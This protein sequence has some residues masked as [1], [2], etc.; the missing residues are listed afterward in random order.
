[1]AKL[2]FRY[3]AMNSGKSTELLQVA[4]N[5]GELGYDVFVIKPAVDDKG[6]DSIVSRLGISRPVDML[7][8]SESGPACFLYPRVK[9]K[10]GCVLVDEAQFL[11]P[12][13]VDALDDFVRMH[14]IPVIAF[15]LRT[16][17][18]GKGFPGS[19]RLLEV[20]DKIDEIKTL[21]ACGSKAT[22]HLRYIDDRLDRGGEQVVID[23]KG[24]VRYESV[25]GQCF[26]EKMK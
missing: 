8:D 25:C 2:Y 17:F 23:N 22:K 7:W 21:C 14:D 3:G 10:L 6:E 12:E 13:Q 9:R 26:F 15:G 16:D 1:M 18:A 11:T 4:H 5:Y 20:A 24:N 19:T